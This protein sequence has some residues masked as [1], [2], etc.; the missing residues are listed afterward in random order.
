VSSRANAEI[1]VAAVCAKFDGGGHV[2]AAG[3]TITAESPEDALA[4]AVD[5][6]GEAVRNYL[7][8]ETGE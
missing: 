2:R 8:E 5:A 4:V 6:F 7:F 3:C 1:D